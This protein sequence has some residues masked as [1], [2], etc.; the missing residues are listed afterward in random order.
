MAAN[1]DV[2][3]CLA[4]VVAGGQYFR[5]GGRFEP[6]AIRDGPN[7][8]VLLD[9]PY[10]YRFAEILAAVVAAVGFR[11]GPVL[12]RGL[13]LEGLLK[14]DVSFR[15]T[16]SRSLQAASPGTEFQVVWDA[17]TFDCDRGPG[18]VTR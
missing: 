18:V 11:C 10:L 13:N 1:S 8:V 3:E 6:H 16:M 14:D 4:A 7:A 5:V 15:L 17:N 12:N 9:V 2:V